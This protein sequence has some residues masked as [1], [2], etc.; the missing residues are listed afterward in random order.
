MEGKGEKLKVVKVV[1][2]DHFSIDIALNEVVL[3]LVKKF[4]PH[5]EFDLIIFILPL[6]LL[7][8][9]G[10]GAFFFGLI[11]GFGSE[12]DAKIEAELAKKK[13]EERKTVPEAFNKA[14]MMSLE[15]WMDEFVI[16][17]Q[18]QRRKPVFLLFSMAL[19]LSG[20]EAKA[21]VKL[22][23]PRI[24]DSVNVFLSSLTPEQLSGYDGIRMLR[25]EIW[26]RANEIL[27]DSTSLE[28]IQILKLT[29]K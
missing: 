27:E 9:A 13:A 11:P 25:Q 8:G 17:L 5:F 12:T 15:F 23:E 7:I 14:S 22:L 20:E 24:R 2:V 19:I 4:W 16:N 18:T 3:L 21:K 1:E 10:A 26:N 6:V 29:I 28:N